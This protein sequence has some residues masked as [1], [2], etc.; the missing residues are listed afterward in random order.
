MEDA[1]I[2]ELFWQRDEAALTEAENSY[3]R[4][5]LT[6]A[7]NILG[8]AQDAQECVNDTFLGAWNAIPPHRPDSLRAFLGK[9]ARRLAIKK[10]RAKTA[11]KRGGG[12][13]AV[14]FDELDELAL[15]DKDIDANLT[16]EELARIM[17]TFVEGL[18]VDER[19]VFVCRYWRFDSIGDISK[20]YGF[21]QGKVKSMLRRT[22]EK[23]KARLV[24]EGV[25][26]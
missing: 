13:V 18:S 22:R 7:N 15:P 19:R 24:E 9:I 23:L 1:R 5:C 26:V 12:N 25:W 2:V 11:D 20:R 16:D 14:S 8:D 3:G 10:W 17:R 21:T 6:I 4:Y